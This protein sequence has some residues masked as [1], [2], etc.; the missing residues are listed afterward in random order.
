MS[1][2]Q[3]ENQIWKQL[4]A[5]KVSTM[6]SSYMMWP[7]FSVEAIK[8][9]RKMEFFVHYWQKSSSEYTRIIVYLMSLFSYVIGVW[10]GFLNINL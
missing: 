9:L 7:N 6:D 1:L 3:M 4:W 8:D 2:T 10:S 5:F